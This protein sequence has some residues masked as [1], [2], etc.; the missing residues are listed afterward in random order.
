MGAVA[1][2]GGSPCSLVQGTRVSSVLLD[3]PATG[4]GFQGWVPNSALPAALADGLVHASLPPRVPASARGAGQN[5]R[6]LVK[7]G[8]IIRKPQ[9]I[10][11]R[12][13]ARRAAEAKSKGRHTGYG[14]EGRAASGG[15]TRPV[16]AGQPCLARHGS[17][18]AR[19]L[20]DATAASRGA[21]WSGAAHGARTGDGAAYCMARGGNA[22]PLP[23]GTKQQTVG[24]SAPSR[25]AFPACTP[26]R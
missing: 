23:S 8:F 21:C 13:R 5:V 6:K 20:S 1:A 3:W 25:P 9:K 12:S 17:A 24:G 7:D 26:T 4:Q 10:H 2:C 16:G 14:E 19:Q 11:S 15:G 18:G 22:G